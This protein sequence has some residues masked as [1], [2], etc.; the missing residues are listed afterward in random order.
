M[1]FAQCFIHFSSPADGA[2][3]VDGAHHFPIDPPLSRHGQSSESEPAAN[4]I[5]PTA[6]ANA[7]KSSIAAPTFWFGATF[8]PAL[9]GRG[10]SP[11][12]CPIPV[13]GGVFPQ[14]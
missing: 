9:E 5:A 1:F 13:S 7:D 10:G 8:R 11:A 12:P 2:G 6:S 4:S 3:E 14:G